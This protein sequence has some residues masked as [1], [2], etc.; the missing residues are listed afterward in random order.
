MMYSVFDRVRRPL[1]ASLM[2]ALAPLAAA[3]AQQP[4]PQKPQA[5]RAGTLTDFAG[6]ETFS[7]MDIQGDQMF[8][9]LAGQRVETSGIVTLLT[10]DRRSFWIQDPKGDGNAATSDGLFVTLGRQPQVAERPEVGD[11]VR[12]IGFVE[13]ELRDL[14]LPRTRLKDLVKLEI[15]GRG[16]SLPAPVP[17]V[18]V[19]DLEIPQAIAFWEGLEGMRV[20]L[21]KGKVVG[22]TN[23]Y[24]EWVVL[25]ESNAKAGS[26][27]HPDAGV[28]L[29]TDLGNGRVDYNPERIPIGSAT[30]DKRIVARL[31]DEVENLVGVLD[32][33]FSKYRVQPESL[34]MK[35]QE[36]PSAP[37][38]RRSGP[39]GDVKVVSYN[40]RDLFDGVDNPDRFDENYDPGSRKFGTRGR[41]ARYSC[42]ADR[43]RCRWCRASRRR[44][45]IRP[46]A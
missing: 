6:M 30:L 4:K 28:M 38:S 11:V 7:I 24:G 10:K 26:G 27:Y 9:P 40:L 21:D 3:V 34:E 36:P 17:L 15:V 8:S 22:P 45:P 2:L 5:P 25:A 20:S 37:A 46:R 32:F 23:R 29:T 19:P 12:V 39:P 33:T 13:E 16:K 31:G 1:C 44:S 18:D 41:G 14:S 35:T 43:S 42:I